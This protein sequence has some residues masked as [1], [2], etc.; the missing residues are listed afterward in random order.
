[1]SAIFLVFYF[2][3]GRNGSGPNMENP[4]IKKPAPSTTIAD[5]DKYFL[6][7]AYPQTGHST[8]Y[9]TVPDENKAPVIEGENSEYYIS[10][11]KNIGLILSTGD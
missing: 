2:S 6:S 4:S 9:K 1:M 8:V 5:L 7:A 3:N 11:G 10:Y